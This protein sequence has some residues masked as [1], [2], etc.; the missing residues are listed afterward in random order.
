MSIH[1]RAPPAGGS[2]AGWVATH[3]WQADKDVECMVRAASSRSCNCHSSLVTTWG[4]MTALEPRL[5]G[6]AARLT[7]QHGGNIF[8]G[9]LLSG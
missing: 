8:T 9:R 4:H 7:L 2:S 3:S 5:A 6:L 1:E